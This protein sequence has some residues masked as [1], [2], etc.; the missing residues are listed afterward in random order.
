MVARPRVLIV[1]TQLV[2]RRFQRHGEIPDFHKCQLDV[3]RPAKASAAKLGN[4]GSGDTHVGT[5]RARAYVGTE[6]DE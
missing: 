2:V 1:A 6:G 5:E 3:E 4:S